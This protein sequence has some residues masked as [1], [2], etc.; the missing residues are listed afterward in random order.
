MPRSG[1]TFSETRTRNDNGK[2]MNL[3][4]DLSDK[5]TLILGKEKHTWD[6]LYYLSETLL[7]E[8]DHFLRKNK[9]KLKDIQKIKVIPG[10]K[11]IVSNRIAEAVAL[12]LTF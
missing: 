5:P 8:I 11:S 12:G 10:G 7:S 1:F 4:I 6:G 2:Q 3:I 9:V